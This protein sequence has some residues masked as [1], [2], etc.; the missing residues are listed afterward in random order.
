[1]AG[2]SSDSDSDVNIIKTRFLI[3][4]QFSSK[5]VIVYENDINKIIFRHLLTF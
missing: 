1:M 3:D 5:M 2:S 4:N